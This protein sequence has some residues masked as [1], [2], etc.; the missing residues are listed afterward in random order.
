MSHV[1]QGV[2]IHGY[3]DCRDAPITEPLIRCDDTQAGHS[4]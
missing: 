2:N 4:L 3:S 1:G